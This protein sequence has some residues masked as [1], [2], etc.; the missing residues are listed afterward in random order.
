MKQLKWM[1]ALAAVAM[2]AACAPKAKAPKVLVLYYS[3]TA[4]T[5]A[6][7]EEIATRLNADLEEITPEVP[8]GGSYME[9][10]QRSR[11]ERESGQLPAVLPLKA[12]LAAYDV[13]FLGYPIW[14]GTYALPVGSLLAQADFA[15]KK[16]VPFCTFGSGG[17]DSSV[18]DLKEHCPDAEILP[19]Y[20][21]RAA[22]MDAVPKEI[23][24]FLKAGG[25]LE[26][27]AVNLEEFPEQH[28]VTEEEAAIFDAAVGDYPMI[29]AKA[30]TVASRAIPGGM[31]Y[32]FTA[33][34]K[35]RE[36]APVPM[37]D[38]EPRP[39]KVYVTV[40]EGQAPVFTQVAR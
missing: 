35:P 12:D 6:V 5:K 13:V 24:Q 26:G 9:T 25:Y 3:Q 18:R 19:G 8:Y 4:T 36:G 40:E 30:A 21:V 31:E 1:L 11:E 17:L 16:V 38:M 14:F 7:A 10:I 22:R 29:S 15:G 33:F 28:E 37:P 20:G 23:D 32:L 34:D 27:E 2:L 39:M